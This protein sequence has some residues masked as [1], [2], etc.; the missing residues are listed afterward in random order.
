MLLEAR[1]IIAQYGRIRVLHG[2]DL[3][4][5]NG[6]LVAIIGANGAGKTTLLRVLSGVQPLTA[7]RISFDGMPFDRVP[8]YRRVENG[9]IQIPEGRQIF[10][11]MTVEDN[12]RLGGYRRRGSPDTL[13]R[14]YDAFPMLAERRHAR[15]SSLSGGQQQVL[16]LARALMGD[17]RLLLLDEPSM[18][19]APLAVREVYDVILRLRHEGVTICLVEQNARAALDIADRAYVL[20]NGTITFSGSAA[21]I[22]KDDTIR[23]AYLAH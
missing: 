17:P 23:R 20:E 10:G 18:G 6:E 8:P 1:N 4:V 11:A 3:D 15:A 16:A 19:L 13:K 12:M 2:I 21:E 22:G 9:I 5:A 7:G 14:L